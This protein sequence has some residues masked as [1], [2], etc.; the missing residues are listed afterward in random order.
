MEAKVSERR[1]LEYR[2]GDERV[3]PVPVEV[4]DLYG[5]AAS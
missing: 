2:V 1:T 5:M 4:G 3:V